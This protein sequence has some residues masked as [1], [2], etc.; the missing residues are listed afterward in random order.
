[1]TIV[2]S[3]TASRSLRTTMP[4]GARVTVVRI[5]SIG[6]AASTHSAPCRADAATPVTTPS[7]CVHSHAATVVSRSVRMRFFGAWMFGKT[8]R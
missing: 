5:S 3:S 1:M 6:V 2:V 8:G 4:H 7:R